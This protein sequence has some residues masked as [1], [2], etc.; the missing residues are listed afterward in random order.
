MVHK[1]DSNHPQTITHSTTSHIKQPILSL[2][3]LLRQYKDT[4]TVV[5]NEEDLTL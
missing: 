4:I 2:K 3:S 1:I 5:R